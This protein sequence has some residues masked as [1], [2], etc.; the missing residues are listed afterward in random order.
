[1]EKPIAI[2]SNPVAR[3]DYTRWH[4][5]QNKEKYKARARAHNIATRK[6]VRNALL[7]YLLRHPCVD[8][9]ESDPVVLEFD[10]RDS[11]TK[12]FNVGDAMRMVYSLARVMREVEK[13]DVRCANCHRRKT[14][15]DAGHTHRTS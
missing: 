14:Y 3:K 1:M 6:N 15:V 9:G 2:R 13:C 12:D 11:T 7:D 4:Y 8:C 5:Q 10:H